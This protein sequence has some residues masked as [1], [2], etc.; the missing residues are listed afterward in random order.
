MGTTN[1]PS[2]HRNNESYSGATGAFSLEGTQ[3]CATPH[4]TSR[5]RAESP[6]DQDSGSIG[7][8]PS[9]LRWSCVPG[10]QWEDIQRCSYNGRYGWTQ[11]W[12]ILSDEETVHIQAE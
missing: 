6:S 4:S 7:D 1:L 5:T 9:Q 11:A 3:Y 2:Q 10:A 8:H 12:G